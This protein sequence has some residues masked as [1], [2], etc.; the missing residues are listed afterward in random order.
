MAG[1]KSKVRTLRE[2]SVNHG[3][4]ETLAP[5]EMN[6]QP[7]ETITYNRFHLFSHTKVG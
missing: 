6:D 1:P 7:R 5:T 3:Q 4:N 2:I